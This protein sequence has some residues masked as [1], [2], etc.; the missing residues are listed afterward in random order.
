VGRW[1]FGRPLAFRTRKA[2]LAI[3]A[4]GWV[5]AFVLHGILDFTYFDY[6]RIPDPALSRTVPYEVKHT[7]VY[8]TANQRDILDWLQRIEIVSGV[9]ILISLLMNQK[10]PIGLDK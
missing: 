3:A 9:L 6:S 2:I 7:I 8:I 5:A 10:W 1:T 4:F